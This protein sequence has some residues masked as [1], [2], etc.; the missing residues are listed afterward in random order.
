MGFS[1]SRVQ[2]T[3]V[4]AYGSTVIVTEPEAP[5][6][7]VATTVTLGDFVDT[8]VKVTAVVAGLATTGCVLLLIVMVF[9]SDEVHVTLRCDETSAPNVSC[10]V[11][12]AVVEFVPS[13]LSTVAPGRSVTVWTWPITVIVA[14]PLALLFVLIAVIVAEPA[15]VPVAVTRPLAST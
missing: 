13:T 1:G 12:V 10:K 6:S 3:C 11:A 4:K 8:A 15:A 9:G 5:S 14:D 7:V 2:W